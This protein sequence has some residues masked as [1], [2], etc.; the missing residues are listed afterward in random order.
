[1]RKFIDVSGFG[2]TGKSFAFQLLGSAFN[3]AKLHP[4]AEF[5]LFRAPG[6]LF[7]LYIDTILHWSP[8][9]SSKAISDFKLLNRRLS[10]CANLSNPFSFFKS[11]GNNYNKVIN[12]GFE[13]LGEDFINEIIELTFKTI[14]PYNDFTSSNINFIVS[15]ISSK[16]GYTV[17]YNIELSSN[18]SLVVKKFEKYV[19]DL[20]NLF[21]EEKDAVVI[22]SN[23]I[24]PYGYDLL[25][26]FYNNFNS[27]IIDRD[28]RDVYTTLLPNSGLTPDFLRNSNANK[29]LLNTVLIDLDDFISRF[30]LY[31]D[32]YYK[33]SK[34]NSLNNFRFEDIVNDPM[35]FLANVSNEIN[36]PILPSFDVEIFKASQKNV[37]IY[38]DYKESKF[39]KRIEDE[40]S[41]YCYL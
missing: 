35:A 6:G 32:A 21:T 27:I 33:Y 14:W 2:N 11:S 10:T 26:G 37:G 20:L 39:I 12:P 5:E 22:L 38:K 7:D 24:E 1:M 13:K 30:K 8:I 9:R 18:S 4:E 40:L 29:A 16:L 3:S 19:N 31:H 28:P 23:A 15:K 17:K 34:F 36:L 25:K 41:D